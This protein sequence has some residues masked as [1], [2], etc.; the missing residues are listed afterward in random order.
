MRAAIFLLRPVPTGLQGMDEE[1]LD[2]A[3]KA[4][5]AKKASRVLQTSLTHRAS[6]PIPLCSLQAALQLQLPF[7]VMGVFCVTWYILSLL[8]GDI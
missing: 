2:T 6:V 4:H 5:K 1:T 8:L 7:G 3:P